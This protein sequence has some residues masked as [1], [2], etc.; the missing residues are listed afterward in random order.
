M[1]RVSAALRR[2]G[3]LR[4]LVIGVALAL[5]VVAGVLSWQTRTLN[6]DPVLDNRALLDTTRQSGVI[7]SV[8]RGLTEVLSYD[9]TQPTATQAFA[10]QVL[11]GQARDQFDTLFASLKERAPGQKLTLSALVQVA[12][13]E[14]LSNEK[15]KLLVFLDQS[16]TRAE[17]DQKSVSAAQLSVTAERKGRTWVITGL[18]PL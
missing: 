13:V 10:D 4:G 16:S 17:D 7:T 18:T 12:G 1:S 6:H 11:S 2:V 9:Y 8:T 15:A 14:Q 3:N 5:A